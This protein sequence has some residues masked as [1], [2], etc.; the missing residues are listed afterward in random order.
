VYGVKTMHVNK[1]VF[2][3][4]NLLLIKREDL[5]E[6]YLLPEIQHKYTELSVDIAV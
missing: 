3:V 4:D 5:I 1:H 2:R 6:K